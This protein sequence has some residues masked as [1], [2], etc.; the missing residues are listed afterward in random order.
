MPAHVQFFPWR[1]RPRRG[2]EAPPASPASLD[3]QTEQAAR[4]LLRQ[5]IADENGGPKLA[6]KQDKKISDWQDLENR[7]T[8]PSSSTRTVVVQAAPPPAAANKDQSG[9]RPGQ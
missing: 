1:E 8:P 3:P 7:A 9:A 2:E 4:E 6:A 5:K